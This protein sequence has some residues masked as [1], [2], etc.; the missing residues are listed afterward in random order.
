MAVYASGQRRANRGWSATR[1]DRD[2]RQNQI[3]SEARP[4][5]Q[6]AAAVGGRGSGAKLGKG[7]AN[8]KTQGDRYVRSPTR[9]AA[10]RGGRVGRIP[11][12]RRREYT[13]G[14]DGAERFAPQRG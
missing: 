12:R 9:F 1:P 4:F 5:R 2:R 10:E 7:S 6:P 8:G 14:L 11:K 3:G 13:G